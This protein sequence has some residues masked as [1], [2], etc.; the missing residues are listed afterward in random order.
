[1]NEAAMNNNQVLDLKTFVP[2]KD[3]KLSQRFYSD[4]GFT[5]NWSNE[6]VADADSW[7]QHIN[8][9]GLIQKYPDILIGSHR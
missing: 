3:Y 5:L 1:M 7:W 9:I 6:Q 8:D 4:L 2:A